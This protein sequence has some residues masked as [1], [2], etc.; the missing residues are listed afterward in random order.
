VHARHEPVLTAPRF[1]A[2][3]PPG[4]TRPSVTAGVVATFLALTLVGPSR[5]GD[6]SGPAPAATTETPSAQGSTEERSAE[7]AP[8]PGRLNLTGALALEA[9]GMRSPL[10][11]GGESST[12][13]DL[14]LRRIELAVEAP[15]LQGVNAIA[16]VNSEWIGDGVN[17]GDAALA[18]DEVHLDLDRQHGYLIVGQRTQPF[19]VFENHLVTEPLTQDAYEIKKPGATLGARGPLGA[20][21]SLTVYAGGALWDHFTSSRLLD[22]VALNRQASVVSHVSS[23][24]VAASFSPWAERVSLSGALDSEPGRGTRNTTANVA[25]RLVPHGSS[26]L[27]VDAEVVRAL[28]R[29]RDAASGLVF[30]ETAGSVSVAYMFVVRPRKL[31]GNASYKARRSHLRAHPILVCA[32]YEFLDDDGLTTTTTVATVRQRISLGGRYA[33]HEENGRSAYFSSEYRRT[34]Y[35]VPAGAAPSERGQGSELYLRLGIDF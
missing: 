35:H 13:S 29:E 17:P 4:F 6:T 25:L 23:Y 3:A 7:A 30:K 11:P 5:G 2:G 31:R 1:R 32:R 8:A 12:R 21:V 19:G 9:R 34:A 33:F 28:S 26:H 27:I 22:V 15:M 14:Y 16:V 18:V 20:D 10:T 24:V